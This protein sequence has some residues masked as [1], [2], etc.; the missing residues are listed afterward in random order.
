MSSKHSSPISNAVVG[1][2]RKFSVKLGY[3][4]AVVHYGDIIMKPRKD[5]IEKGAKNRGLPSLCDWS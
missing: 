5:D 1:K 4:L 2:M 3:V